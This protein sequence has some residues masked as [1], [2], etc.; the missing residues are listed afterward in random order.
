MIN[1]VNTCFFKPLLLLKSVCILTW[2]LRSSRI[3][4]WWNHMK[5]FLKYNFFQTV[6]YF[7][8]PFACLLA[9]YV[10]GGLFDKRNEGSFFTWGFR[11][12]GY[13]YPRHCR[14][15][16]IVLH[17]TQHE[18]RLSDSQ[19]DFWI[20]FRC[21][22]EWLANFYPERPENSSPVS[23]G[24]RSKMAARRPWSFFLEMNLTAERSHFLQNFRLHLIDLS[25]RLE[26]DV[27]EDVTDYVLVRLHQASLIAFV[28]SGSQCGFRCIQR[29]SNLY[30]CPKGTIYQD[31]FIYIKIDLYISSFIH[32]C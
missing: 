11:L 25:R 15:R 20:R 3:I 27:N 6:R 8:N 30:A 31:L 23:P 24:H 19:N 26:R 4:L 16:A 7:W 29:S 21:T 32:Q 10:T 12:H 13:V 22:T 28:K 5:Q 18:T 14:K 9:K 1:F 17:C 2:E